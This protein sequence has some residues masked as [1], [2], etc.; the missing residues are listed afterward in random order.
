MS[1][2]KG[3][4]ENCVRVCKQIFGENYY[5]SIGEKF[6]HFTVPRENDPNMS[7]ERRVLEELAD[8]INEVRATL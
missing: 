1:E 4:P 6:V 5:I 2:D 3:L 7:R 8:T